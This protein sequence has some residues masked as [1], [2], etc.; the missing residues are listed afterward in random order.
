MCR[1]YIVEVLYFYIAIWPIVDSIATPQHKICFT[2][3]TDVGRKTPN[4]NPNRASGAGG[5]WAGG[6]DIYSDHS[7]GKEILYLVLYLFAMM[8]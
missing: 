3:D 1:M 8:R 6:T 7:T 4:Y 2:G 5:Q